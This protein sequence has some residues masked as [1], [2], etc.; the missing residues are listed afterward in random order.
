[1]CPKL[2]FGSVLPINRNTIHAVDEL[3]LDTLWAGG[4]GSPVILAI[5]RNRLGGVYVKLHFRAAQ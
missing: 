1:M 5:H 4:D 3:H 2:F